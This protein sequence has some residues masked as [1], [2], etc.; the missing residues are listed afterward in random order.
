MALA[1]VGSHC[2]PLLG[3]GDSLSERTVTSRLMTAGKALVSPNQVFSPKVKMALSQKKD[4]TAEDRVV[5]GPR[6]W[7][8]KETCVVFHTM[9]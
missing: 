6:D 4:S 7:G 9:S 2:V 5:T 3:Q 1:S 8:D